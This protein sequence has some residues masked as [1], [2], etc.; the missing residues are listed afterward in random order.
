MN[1]YRVV[2]K[3]IVSPDG[4]V[5]SQAKSA[6]SSVGDNTEIKQSVSV[7]MSSSGCSSSS[8]ASSSSS[9]VVSRNTDS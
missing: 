3:W 5:V 9:S 6:A 1:Q 4:T 8:S 2:T 7:S